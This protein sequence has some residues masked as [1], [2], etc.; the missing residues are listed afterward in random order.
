MSNTGTLL[1]LYDIKDLLAGYTRAYLNKKRLQRHQQWDLGAFEEGRILRTEDGCIFAFV[2]CPAITDSDDASARQ[3]VSANLQEVF[4]NLIADLIAKE[5]QELPSNNIKIAFGINHLNSHWTGLLAEFN[6]LD[7]NDYQALYQAHAAH[8]ALPENQAQYVDESGNPKSHT[9]QVNNVKNFLIANC[10]IVLK[11]ADHGNWQLPLQP[12]QM[13]LRHLD[14]IGTK[15]GYAQNVYA[16]SKEF[17]RTHRGT[18][19]RYERCSRQS[20]NTCGDWTVF[21][22][23]TRGVLNER[24]EATSEILRSLHEN[25]TAR[26]AS[27]VLYTENPKMLKPTARTRICVTKEERKMVSH[28]DYLDELEAAKTTLGQIRNM[29]PEWEGVS[30]ILF[31]STLAGI[32]YIGLPWLMP[33]SFLVQCGIAGVAGSAGLLCFNK[34]ARSIFGQH[35]IKVKLDSSARPLKV[36]YEKSEG[37][38][39]WLGLSATPYLKT[40]TELEQ[41]IASLLQNKE[42]N[43]AKP[44]SSTTSV[45]K[46]NTLSRY[47]ARKIVTGHPNYFYDVD[48]RAVDNEKYVNEKQAR[49]F[50]RA[51]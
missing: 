47:Y 7:A 28:Q 6:G 9:I 44:A 11:S 31:A 19:F 37:L 35:N 41:E 16:A 48:R 46:C 12:N 51:R 29:L 24:K 21:N 14:S 25:L 18:K 20:G 27:S 49:R 26:N 50:L 36:A 39:A 42:A 17:M 38:T 8:A 23:F 45:E 13:L 15:T 34:L 43:S 40:L 4:L 3:S 22:T 30:R 5:Y 10:G 1:G 33:I 32:C 2:T